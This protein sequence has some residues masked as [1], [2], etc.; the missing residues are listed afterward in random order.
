MGDPT[1]PSHPV[2]KRRRI[3]K[4]D[5]CFSYPLHGSGSL[6]LNSVVKRQ[7]MG[8]SYNF[9]PIKT[10][11]IDDNRYNCINF[12]DYSHESPSKAIESQM[13]NA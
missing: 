1:E 13:K 12:I 2:E 3:K 10:G 5:I 9:L 11:Y 4:V 8:K 7:F 6:I